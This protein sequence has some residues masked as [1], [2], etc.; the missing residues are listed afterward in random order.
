VNNARKIA[1]KY[2]PFGRKSWITAAET[3]RMPYWDWASNAR[4]PDFLNTPSL[5]ITTPS[6]VQSVTNP[7]AAYKFQSPKNQDLFPSQ[8]SIAADWY[9]SNPSQ[10]LRNPDVLGG[11]SNFERA[12]DELANN[13]FKAQTVSIIPSRIDIYAYFTT[14]VQFIDQ[15]TE[16]Q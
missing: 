4:M 7:L 15:S 13:G 14:T 12:N 3:L 11:A 8:Q 16:F 5:T 9:L 1:N 6:G 10:T 2:P